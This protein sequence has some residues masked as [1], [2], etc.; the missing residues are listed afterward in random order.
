MSIRLEVS[1]EFQVPS[2]VASLI[3]AL[4][5][6][7]DKATSLVVPGK[8]IS[9]F[10]VAR[11]LPP[12]VMIVPVSLSTPIPPIVNVPLASISR[13]AFSPVQVR[14]FSRSSVA[15]ASR[16]PL[17]STSPALMLIELLSILLLRLTPELICTSPP[18]V[19]SSNRSAWIKPP[20]CRKVP[21]FCDRR[22]PKITSPSEINVRR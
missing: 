17:I 4:R 8:S 20:N 9:I 1:G 14:F 5:L 15:P 16:E 3:T 7:T 22:F 11:K 6:L 19:I 2:P 18:E 21:S 12:R 13:A 10:P